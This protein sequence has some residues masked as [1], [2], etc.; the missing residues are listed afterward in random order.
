MTSTE[1]TGTRAHTV[2]VTP[3]GQETAV[4][5]DTHSAPD[6][7]E[8]A[9]PKYLVLLPRRSVKLSASGPPERNHGTLT[10]LPPALPEAAAAATLGMPA[11]ANHCSSAPKPIDPSCWGP[12]GH[13]VSP[14]L[15]LA[16]PS[17]APHTVSERGHAPTRGVPRLTLWLMLLSLL[18]TNYLLAAYHLLTTLFPCSL[19]Q[20]YRNFAT[21]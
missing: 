19:S 17:I 21:P 16:S 12:S 6:D 10:A 1:D 15:H 5:E 8:L 2:T 14:G 20:A 9:M 7:T 3:T 18:C 4:T 11:P 13:R